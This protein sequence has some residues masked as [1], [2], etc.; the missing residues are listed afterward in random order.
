M[1]SLQI[2]DDMKHLVNYDEKVIWALRGSDVVL[3]TDQR[4]IIRKTG[5]LGLK[6]S[7]VDYPYSNMV[8]IKLDRGLYRASVEILMRSGVQNIRI[9][10]LSKADAY[11]LHRV[12][13]EN[14][15]KESAFPSPQTAP[16]IIQT[17]TPTRNEAKGGERLCEECGH[18]VSED[19]ALCP[20]CRHP[21]KV[22]CPECGK[23]VDSKFKSCPYCGED[24]S[25]AEQMDR[26]F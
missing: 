11:Q 5:G 8:N 24:L 10:S 25:Y 7:F 22:E 2:P 16:V 3:V 17:P 18:K 12:I 26:D 4:I 13:R 6:R 19:F 14:I 23:R 21:L 1:A 20:F 15:V 9:G